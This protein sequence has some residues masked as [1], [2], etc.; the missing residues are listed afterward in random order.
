LN[1]GKKKLVEKRNKRIRPALDDKIIL[2]WN[3]L[4]NTACSK[5]FAATGYEP[6]RQL[7]IGNM[8]FLLENFSSNNSGEFF[9][10][11]KN[12]IAKYPA[13]L[14]DYAFLIDALIHLQEITADIKWLQM[15][16]EITG[17]VIENFSDP[18]DLF[19]FYTNSGQQDVI[20]RKKE[21]Y[22]GAIPSGNAV[23]A[24][25]LY[26][27][28]I[29]F[30]KKEWK[31]RSNSMVSTLVNV[32]TK[33]PTSFGI[34]ACLL[35][36][37]ITGTAEIAVV[38]TDFISLQTELLRQYIP[39]KVLMA[40]KK[41]IP[42]FPLLANK[43]STDSASIYLCSNYTCHNSVIS[44]KDLISLIDSTNNP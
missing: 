35:Q 43:H 6:Y 11:W 26:R 30:D 23:M 5:A 29:L 20:I 34:W 13:F 36:E 9:H 2:G 41:A 7:A 40:T 10:T 12:D 22:D 3:T 18:D 44:V 27:L 1:N 28:S 25:N 32:I 39:H 17:F 21:M 37:I 24:Y 4:M 31:Q 38:G 33:Y 19:F 14:D 42:E 15:A 16:K 8:R